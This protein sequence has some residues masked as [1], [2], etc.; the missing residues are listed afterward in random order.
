MK[1]ITK[2]Q[3]EEAAKTTMLGLAKGGALGLALAIPALHFASK[4]YPA[5]R[6]IPPVQRG[7]LMLIAT[8][9]AGMTNAELSYE[10]YLKSQ[11]HGRTAEILRKEQEEEEAGIHALSLQ[12]RALHWAKENRFG[13]IGMSWVTAMAVSGGL[14]FARNRGV[15]FSQKIVQVRMY[16]QGVTIAVLLASAGLSAIHLPDEEALEKSE[17]AR[18]PGEAWKLMVVTKEQQEEAARATMWGGFRGAV[19]GLTV[20]LPSLYIAGVFYPAV[21]RIPVVQKTWL[22]L[23]ATLGAGATN[24]EITYNDYLAMQ[25]YKRI[26]AEL[27]E[28]QL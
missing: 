21:R 9:G 4:R 27:E 23:I 1:L 7:W 19:L 25:R 22:M 2:Q 5:V 20:G 24:A 11:W 15:P 28:R 18:A 10:A 8:L 16:A 13:I 3:Q 6:A 12:G 14:V 26:M 17:K